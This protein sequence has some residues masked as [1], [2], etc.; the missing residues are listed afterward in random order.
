MPGSRKSED[1]PQASME[2]MS[3]PVVVVWVDGVSDVSVKGGCL[4]GACTP[5]EKRIFQHVPSSIPFSLAM[6]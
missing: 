5:T 1:S 3:R 6:D 2:A 4:I